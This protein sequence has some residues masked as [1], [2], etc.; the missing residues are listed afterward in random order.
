MN[1]LIDT[2]ILIPLEDTSRTLDPALAEMRRMSEQNGHVLFT[3]PSQKEDI[4]RDKDK[5]RRDIMLSRLKQYQTI[6][7]PPPLSLDELE[8]YGWSQANDNDRIDNLLLHALGRGAVH[9]L[10]TDDKDI[11]KKAKQ[12]QVQ[13]Q[14]PINQVQLPY[15][16]HVHE[17]KILP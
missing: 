6:P 2:N 4:Q 15:Y 13:E 17:L 9:F 16:F 5:K 1:V 3:H 12:V 14:V 8:Q 7:S 10:V 11:H